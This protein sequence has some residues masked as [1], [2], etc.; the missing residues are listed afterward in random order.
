MA[1]TKLACGAYERERSAWFATWALVFA[2][3]EAAEPPSRA[4]VKP[5]SW[6][7]ARLAARAVTPAGFR[8]TAHSIRQTSIKLH[9]A[10]YSRISHHYSQK[11]VLQ[12]FVWSIQ[13]NE[14]SQP[15]GASVYYIGKR[16]RRLPCATTTTR[17]DCI[18]SGER[19]LRVLLDTFYAFSAAGTHDK[20]DKLLLSPSGTSFQWLRRLN[21]ARLDSA[22]PKRKV[23]QKSSRTEPWQHWC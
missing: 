12:P 10:I 20:V 7:T 14:L 15:S 9:A 13:R 8:E 11:I 2:R 1:G 3:L 5:Y 19:R 4:D 23:H 18:K 16:A 21:A 22:H 17:I 6:L